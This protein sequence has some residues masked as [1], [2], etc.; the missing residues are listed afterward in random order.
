MTTNSSEN[1][2]TTMPS[3]TTLATTTAITITTESAT[4]FGATQMLSTN[5]VFSQ[6]RLV[7]SLVRLIG[8]VKDVFIVVETSFGLMLA[9]NRKDFALD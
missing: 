7:H 4:T 8:L 2:A 1:T 6:R 3:L 9:S 5:R